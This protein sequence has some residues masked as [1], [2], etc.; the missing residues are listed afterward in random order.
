MFFREFSQ[1][2]D[3]MFIESC[4]SDIREYFKEIGVPEQYLPKV[5]ISETYTGSWYIE[6]VLAM[7]GTVGTIYVI[8]KGISEL[9]KIADGL[10]DLKSRIKKKFAKKAN[11]SVAARIAQGE[12]KQLPPPPSNVVNTDFVIDARPLVALAS[13]SL[14]S[15]KIYLSVAISRNTFTLEN[16]GNEPLQN[17]QIGIFRSDS[18]RNQWAFA[19]SFTGTIPFLSGCQTIVRDVSEF[20][21][22]SQGDL[23]LSGK[24]PIH[25][26]CWIQDQ[27]GIYLFM[28]YLDK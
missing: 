5:K 22:T 25:V 19:D 24:K 4:E 28:F 23:D 1:S 20:K 3:H 11:E 26:D 18:Q 2:W 7:S 27:H 13:E 8:L 15:H 12:H 16:L 21:H 9:P 17:V 6:A 10:T 14:H